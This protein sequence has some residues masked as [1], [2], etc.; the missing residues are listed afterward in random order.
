MTCSRRS[1]ARRKNEIKRKQPKK[2]KQIDIICDHYPMLTI[3][4]K[5][6]WERLLN[7]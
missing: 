5:L 2:K 7:P 6:K 4:C 3:K 1:F